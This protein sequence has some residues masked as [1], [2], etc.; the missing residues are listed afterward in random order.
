MLRK[1]DVPYDEFIYA[2]AQK[3]VTR[4]CR[5]VVQL[6][7]VSDNLDNLSQGKI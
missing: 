2:I 6:V 4:R 3:I 1:V 5:K 7:D